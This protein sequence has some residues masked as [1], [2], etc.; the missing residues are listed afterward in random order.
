MSRA[1]ERLPLWGGRSR[2]PAGVGRNGGAWQEFILAFLMGLSG[3]RHHW[4]VQNAG[5]G[6][7]KR[8]PAGLWGPGSKRPGRSSEWQLGA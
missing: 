5:E 6:L 4:A 3:G 1:R 2:G 8:G 7:Q